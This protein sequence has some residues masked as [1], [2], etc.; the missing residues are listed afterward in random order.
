MGRRIP[1]EIDVRVVEETPNTLYLVLP[2]NGASG[3]LSDKELDAVAG[4]EEYG[5]HVI[6]NWT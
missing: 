3:E 1:A 6:R 5:G 2:P 4:G